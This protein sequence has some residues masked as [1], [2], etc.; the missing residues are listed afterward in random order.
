MGKKKIQ[1]YGSLL[2]TLHSG[3]EIRIAVYK[4]G[5]EVELR[6]AHPD[7]G[8][9]VS[10][11]IHPLNQGTVEGWIHEIGVQCGANISVEKWQWGE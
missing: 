6:F 10:L 9:P 4:A 11:L 5:K 1:Y 8:R 2:A 3:K 7:G